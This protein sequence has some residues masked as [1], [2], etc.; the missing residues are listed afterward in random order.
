MNWE[1]MFLEVARQHRD[2]CIIMEIRFSPGCFDRRNNSLRCI[3]CWYHQLVSSHLH[4]MPNVK[5]KKV[6]H[7]YY[8]F[9]DVRLQGTGYSGSKAE[10]M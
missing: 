1:G 8:Y 10:V 3:E 5:M 2:V 7:G 6:V 9:R 4:H